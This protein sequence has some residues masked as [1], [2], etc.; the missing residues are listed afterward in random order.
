[1]DIEQYDPATGLWT[2]LISGGNLAVTPDTLTC[3][4]L[5][6]I[7]IDGRLLLYAPAVS[8]RNVIMYF[9][10]DDGANFSRGAFS[11]LNTDLAAGSDIKEIRTAYA[12][13]QVLMLVRYNDGAN[14][15][16]AQYAS[17]SRGAR[18]QGVGG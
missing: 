13:D 6:E 8:D 17:T 1:M 14:E 9:S 11:V 15:Q 3:V 7:A 2:S 4:E 12:N 5:L 16:I 10:E 18:S